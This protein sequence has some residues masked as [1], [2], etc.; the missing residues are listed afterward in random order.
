M[1]FENLGPSSFMEVGKH[2]VPIKDKKC[3]EWEIIFLKYSQIFKLNT[4]DISKFA[5]AVAV[6]FSVNVD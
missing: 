2:W 1:N 3:N 4:F 5:V 6:V